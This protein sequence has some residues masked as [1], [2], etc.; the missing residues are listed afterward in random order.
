MTATDLNMTLRF[1]LETGLLISRGYGGGGLHHLTVRN[2]RGALVLPASSI[3]GRLRYHANQ[4]AHMLAAHR[5]RDLDEK[6]ITEL[7]G[8][9]FQQGALYFEDAH[10][11][12]LEDDAGFFREE[13]SGVLISRR[14]GSQVHKH[15]RFFEA[16]PAGLSFE[17]RIEGFIP[18]DSKTTLTT[19]LAA[20]RLL[21][22]LGANKSR[23]MGTI[24]TEITQLSLDGQALD[25]EKT[26][27][28]LERQV[29]GLFGEVKQ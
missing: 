18:R 3:K 28:L 27:E 10:L 7:F 9:T 21:R 14:T 15:L 11:H 29:K 1:H 12:G 13:R 19:L 25:R 22:Q 8:D 4:F 2:S 5:D 17:T 16:I 6:P 20:V 24:R 26:A 23:G